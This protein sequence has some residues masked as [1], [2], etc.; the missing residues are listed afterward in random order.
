MIKI[1]G[2]LC[3]IKDKKINKYVLYETYLHDEAYCAPS[4]ALKS[5]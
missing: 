3:F 5:L 4:T 2:E 1:V